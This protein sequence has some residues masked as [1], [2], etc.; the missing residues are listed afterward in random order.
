MVTQHYIFSY[1]DYTSF[2][3]EVYQHCKISLGV[4]EISF[5]Y[6]SYYLSIFLKELMQT[7]ETQVTITSIWGKWM[8]THRHFTEYEMCLITNNDNGESWT[9]SQTMQNPMA[10]P[11]NTS[12]TIAFFLFQHDTCIKAQFWTHSQQC[13]YLLPSPGAFKANKCCGVEDTQCI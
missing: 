10:Q 3:W 6:L 4:E 7:K 1:T 13:V 2:T 9:K 12:R 5:Y 11:G 8:R